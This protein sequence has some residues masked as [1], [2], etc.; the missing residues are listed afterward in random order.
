MT[1]HLQ[2][3]TPWLGAPGIYRRISGAA[4]LC[5]ALVPFSTTQIAIGSD[6]PD[7]AYQQHLAKLPKIEGFTAVIQK[8]FVVIGDEAPDMVRKRA[9]QTV[10]WAVDK[11][12]QDYFPRDPD[13]II[14]IWL[15]KDHHSYTNHAWTLFHDVPTTKFGY[16]S[17]AKKALVMDISTGGGTLIH[18]MVH[19]F[20]PANFKECPAWF[21]EGFASLFEA[22]SERDGKI[23]GLV[24]WRFKGLE[25][26]IK[27]GKTISFKELT[28]KTGDDFYMADTY[29][30]HYAQARYLFYYLQEHGLLRKYYHEFVKNAKS[31]PTG[32]ATLQRVLGE[33]DMEAFRK[34]WENFILSLRAR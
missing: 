12:K 24:N 27:Q 2:I 14:N 22:A 31:D 10:K 29:T 3:N 9:T 34:K 20:M 6:L 23:V 15:F 5:I 30:S 26:A 4:L 8:P 25:R 32:Y 19:A 28:S 18:E 1:Q 16:Y 21:N 7:S 33:S 13:Q 17:P 11:L